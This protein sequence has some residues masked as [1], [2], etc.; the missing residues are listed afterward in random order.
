VGTEMPS[1]AGGK[2]QRGYCSLYGSAVAAIKSRCSASAPDKIWDQVICVL[3]EQAGMQGRNQ[4][5][6]RPKTKKSPVHAPLTFP[7]SQASNQSLFDASLSIFLGI[8]WS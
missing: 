7:L 4:F 8:Y 6:S 3:S 2:E 1:R 5:S